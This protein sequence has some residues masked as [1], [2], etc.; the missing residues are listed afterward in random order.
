M[1]FCHPLSLSFSVIDGHRPYCPSLIGAAWPG[2]CR[3]R[4]LSHA[5]DGFVKTHCAVRLRARDK[6]WFIYF[7]DAMASV[8]HA[9]A[10]APQSVHRSALMTYLSSPSLIALTGHSSAQV[11]QE[12]HS[13]VIL[14][15]IWNT[16][17]PFFSCRMQGRCQGHEGIPACLT[18]SPIGLLP[19]TPWTQSSY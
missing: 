11:P 19:E 6:S 18:F 16:P 1:F 7:P 15:A 14:Y 2:R 4:Y 8:G 13:S 9:S 12:M 17:Y 10:Q 5:A 3:N